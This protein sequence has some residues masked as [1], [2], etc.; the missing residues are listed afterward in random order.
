M[1]RSTLH[2]LAITAALVLPPGASAQVRNLP[3]TTTDGLTLIKAKAEP[4]TLLGKTGRARD[5]VRRGLAQ[6]DPG[7]W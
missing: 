2:V 7:R 3:L 4:A 1:T 5:G 6:V